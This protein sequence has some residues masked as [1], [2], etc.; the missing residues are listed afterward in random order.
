MLRAILNKSWKQH[1]TKQLLYGHLP[2]ITKTIQA[3]RTRHSGNC[4]RSRDELIRD[5][6]QWTSSH[7]WAKAV[8]PSR[9]YIQQLCEDTRCSP[10][11][12][13]EAMNDRERWRER[14][15][16]IRADGTTRWW[17]WWY[18]L[19][20]NQILR[21]VPI[22][23]QVIKKFFVKLY[24]EV[25][26]AFL[27]NVWICVVSNNYLY[28][29]T[30][31]RTHTHT[32]IHIYVRARV[33]AY[34]RDL[35]CKD[36]RIKKPMYKWV[37]L[38]MWILGRSEKKRKCPGYSTVFNAL[39]YKLAL[40]KNAFRTTHRYKLTSTYTHTHMDAHKFIETNVHSHTFVCIK[41]ALV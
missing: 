30:I 35:A 32:H 9:T 39:N 8:R 21:N 3:R 34:E 28:H 20:W 40:L 38:D 2:P 37:Y 10:E 41:W 15:R 7:E 19:Q 12:L 22:F 33:Y 11:G 23:N 1:P 25:G 17:W 36:L 14:V 29:F 6:L 27:T 16:N 18:W 26:Y 5:V 24:T 31:A 4:W 13:P